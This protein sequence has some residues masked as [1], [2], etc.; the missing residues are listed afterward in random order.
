MKYNPDIHHRRSIRL[1]GYD[2]SSEG[3]YFITICTQNMECLF[4][5]IVE[6]N[7]VLNDIGR[8]VENEWLKTS[9]IRRNIE[10]DEFIIMPDHFHGIIV[11]NESYAKN[12]VG[13]YC[14]TP[15]LHTPNPRFM[16]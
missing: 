10:L 6:G 1:K 9:I 2:Y 8:I 11:I 12:N 13:A 5:E 16:R 4:G 14:N 15:G 7:I 3:A